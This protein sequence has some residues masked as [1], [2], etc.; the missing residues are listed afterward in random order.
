M[1]LLPAMRHLRALMDDP[2]LHRAFV[3]L[4]HE[5]VTMSGESDGNIL[6]EGYLDLCS[7]DREDYLHDQVDSLGRALK[8]TA[9]VWG[10]LEVELVED[11]RARTGR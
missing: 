4:A 1:D 3:G 11:W 10:V 6:D 5:V 9:L 2:A 7:G 8:H